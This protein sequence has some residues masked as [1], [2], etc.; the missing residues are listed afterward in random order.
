[1]SKAPQFA[2]HGGLEPGVAT[3]MRSREDIDAL[4]DLL[5]QGRLVITEFRQ[6]LKDAR[7][8]EAALRAA[9]AES[10][11]VARSALQPVVE[12]ITASLRDLSQTVDRRLRET[13]D[14]MAETV[15][16]GMA[17]TSS[18]SDLSH[19]R[20]GI[21]RDYAKGGEPGS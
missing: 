11:G 4:S 9:I 1:M 16:A 13:A 8:T 3:V 10:K 14:T 5:D 18:E 19:F 2:K 6:I 7:Q 15:T 21:S 17:L 12:E 20:R